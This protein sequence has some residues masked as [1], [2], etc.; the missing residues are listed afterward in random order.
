M[1]DGTH[2]GIRHGRGGFAS[3]KVGKD[4]LTGRERA[5]LAGLKGA[6]AHSVKVLGHS[7]EEYEELWQ[8]KVSSVK[9]QH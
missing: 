1:A 9:S 3:Q 4:G 8:E 7:K 6:I 2:G 5:S